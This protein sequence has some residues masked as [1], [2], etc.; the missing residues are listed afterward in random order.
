LVS[1]IA[2]H[3]LAQLEFTR[4]GFLSPPTVNEMKSGAKAFPS[5]WL[6]GHFDREVDAMAVKSDSTLL[7]PLALLPFNYA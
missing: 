6:S 3:F 7:G 2:R 4:A 5:G 1:T